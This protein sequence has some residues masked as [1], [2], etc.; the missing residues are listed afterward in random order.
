[1]LT[2]LYERQDAIDTGQIYTSEPI[3]MVTRKIRP[4][5]QAFTLVRPF[6]GKNENIKDI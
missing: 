5:S 6:E 3:V 1:M 2:L 4:V